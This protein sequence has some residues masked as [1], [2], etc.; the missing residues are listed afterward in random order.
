[1]DPRKVLIA[2][3]HTRQ[4][5]W[6]SITTHGQL[7]TWVPIA[8]HA[9]FGLLY[10]FGSLRIPGLS[11][12]DKVLESFRWNR[13]ARLSSLRN[14]I[15]KIMAFPFGD[16]VPK[17]K[18]VPF[19]GT[20]SDLLGLK[21]SIWDLQS[22]GRWK[23]LA[24]FKYFI[25][26]QNY[27]YLVITTSSSYIRP[28]LLIKSLS[29]LKT[30]FVY[31]GAVN[32]DA[33]SERFVSGSFTVVNR[34]FAELALRNKRSIPTHLLNDLGL[35]NLAS[36]FKVEPQE[37]RSINIDN[38]NALDSLTGL[39]LSKC[40]H[41]RLKSLNIVSGEREDV[42]LFHRLHTILTETTP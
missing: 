24:L 41:F 2:V 14:H 35:G 36:K 18:E 21:A 27:D 29:K 10:C 31:A 28:D 8:E 42:Q 25:S 22:T 32:G 15:N 26:N 39:E 11:R 5:P 3:Y 7:N 34:N 30:E 37:L 17:V 38:L 9:G 6:E 23:Q 12:L 13:G 1:M 16:I 20:R 19:S 40:V 4:E 33:E